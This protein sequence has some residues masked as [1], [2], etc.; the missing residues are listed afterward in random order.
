MAAI[1]LAGCELGVATAATQI[2]GGNADTN[3]HRWAKLPGQVADNTSPT[4]AADHWNRVDSDI[5]LLQRLGVKHYRMGLEWARIE[6]APG[7]YDTAAI[8]HYVDELKKLKAAGIKPLVTLHH[9]SNPGWLESTGGWL[10]AHTIGVFER[11]VHRVVEAFEDLA[12]DWITVNE[13]N[14]YALKG[15]I[16]GEWPPGRKSLADGVK[17]M[18]HLAYAHI[19]AYKLIHDMQPAANVGA[20]HHLRVFR[21]AQAWNPVDQASS[22]AQEWLFQSALV[23]AMSA[24]KFL[25]PFKQPKYIRPG[26][27]YDFHGINYYGPSEVHFLSNGAGKGVPVNDLGWEIYPQGLAELAKR[28]HKAYPGP[29]YITENGTADANDSFRPLFIFDHLKAA[30]E[31]GAPIARFYHWCFTDN[32][33]WTEGESARFGLLGLDYDTQERVWRD[34]AAFYA[35]ISAN[36]GVT[37]DAYTRWVASRSYRYS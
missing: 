25:P 36:N 8:D 3:W 20:A 37:E 31:S 28:I 32:W 10:K 35:D 24:G 1:S 26:R 12:T 16:E 27:Y 11:Y 13:P 6:P 15:F 30:L 4:R 2:E 17:V 23:R 7:V 18:E 34:S 19:I 14:V 22:A 9:F 29:I 21:P 33:E 5:E